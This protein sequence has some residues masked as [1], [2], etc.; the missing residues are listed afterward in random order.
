MSTEPKLIYEEPFFN[1]TEKTEYS[2]NHPPFYNPEDYDWVKYI[3]SQFPEIK[4]EITNFFSSGNSLK[5][6]SGSMPPNVSRQGSWKNVYF[7]NFLWIKPEGCQLFPKTWN[8]LKQI[9]NLTFA[10][11]AVLEH[12]ST[13]LP[14]CSESNI[15][16]RCHMGI[17]IPGRL[18]ECGI[19]VN[20]EKKSWNEGKVLIFSDCHKHTVWNLTDKRR[21]ILAF[22]VIKDDYKSAKL[23]MCSKYLGAL[24]HR[25]IFNKMPILRK[26]MK[27]LINKL[28]YPISLVWYLFLPL[29]RLIYH[30]YSS[31]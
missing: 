25:F 29:Q 16:M 1:L 4:E 24:T 11:V 6:I 13:V 23:W 5:G 3:E 18:P 28:H 15:N 7:M 2:G 26:F 10:A 21:I 31:I 12:N 27:P 8:R 17:E 9:P 14:H 19:M 30:K 22:D 20:E